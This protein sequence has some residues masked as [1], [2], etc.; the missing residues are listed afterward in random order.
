MAWGP[1][2][3]TV[4]DAKLSTANLDFRTMLG[5]V[6]NL[7]GDFALDDLL[8]VRSAGQQGFT[9]AQF[10]PGLPIQD[11]NVVFA[12]PG[13][14]TLQLTDASWPFA[15]GK[16]SVRPASWTFRDGDQ[17]FAIDVK[18]VDLAKFLGLTKIPNLQVDGKVSGV[19]PIEVRNGSVE[20]VGG[21]LQ[22]RDG[23]GKIRY[24]GPV[25]GSDPKTPP[26]KLPWYQNWFAPKQLTPAEI[27]DQALRGIE[28]EIDVITVD[29]RITGDLT[30]GVVLV[31]ANPQVLSGVPIKLNVK[32][33]LPV[34]QLTDMINRFLETAY[35]ADM[36]K[37]LDKLDRSQN[38]K[39]FSP[40][41]K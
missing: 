8:T 29:G 3:A 35:T 27:A 19:F 9:V 26:K 17:S 13:N 40:A 18:D 25:P 34:G 6:T 30:L 20:I 14:N 4:S 16:L 32:A 38:G 22:A 41:T 2:Q 23:G 28:Y 31:G 33:I 39:V 36:L 1:N 37:E 10:D 21:R 12:L 11:V 24:T 15:E 5:Q 7:T